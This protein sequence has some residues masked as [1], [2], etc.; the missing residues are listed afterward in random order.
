MIEFLTKLVLGLAL[1]VI[2]AAWIAFFA[3]IFI[4]EVKA[5][6]THYKEPNNDSPDAR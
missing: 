3:V 6:Y 5:V 2:L 4:D 1:V